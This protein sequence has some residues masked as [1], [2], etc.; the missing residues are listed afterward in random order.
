M[1][2][3]IVYMTDDNKLAVIIPANSGLSIEDIAKKDVPNGKDYKI[4]DV[5]DLPLDR[6]Y[7]DAW[8]LNDGNVEIDEN[9]KIELYGASE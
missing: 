6:T 9:K 2:K 8:V 4:I 7:R 5:S 3:R 1:N